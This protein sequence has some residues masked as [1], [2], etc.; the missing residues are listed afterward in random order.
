LKKFV[1]VNASLL[2]LF[3]QRCQSLQPDERRLR[4]VP[5]HDLHPFLF[6]LIRLN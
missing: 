1:R 3:R 6:L 4:S 5:V 2:V